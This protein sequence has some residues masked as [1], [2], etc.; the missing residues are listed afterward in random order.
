MNR[1]TFPIAA[2]LSACL[3]NA[4]MAFPPEPDDEDAAQERLEFMKQSV[5]VYDFLSKA[6]GRTKLTLQTEPLIRWNNP[7]SGVKDGTVFIWTAANGRPEAAMQVFLL[8]NDVWLHEC[9]SLSL[10]T[11]AALRDR[12]PVWTP[13][14][15]GLTLQP[16]RDAPAVGKT[17]VRRL[18]QMRTM[19]RDFS[20]SDE[21]EGK[22]RWEL[23]LMP[24]PLYRYG[25]ADTEILDG[26]LFAFAHGTDPE[27]F[28][29][30]EARRQGGDYVWQ[31]G[32]APMTA[33]AVDVSFKRKPIWSQPWKKEPS[34]PKEPFF[35]LTYTP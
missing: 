11:F 28:V 8:R 17:A 23:R 25:K 4:I 1:H 27:V 7:V 22:S 24:N 14:K 29:L 31:F 34:D 35:I 16:V 20:A 10:N 12:R 19:V 15:R 30:L 26:A 32:L 21:F 9:Q 18:V 6:D 3:S 2:L 13:G 33:Y 5:T